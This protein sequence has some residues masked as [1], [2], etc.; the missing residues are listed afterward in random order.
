MS[1]F[2]TRASTGSLRWTSLSRAIPR[3]HC[4]FLGSFAILYS[5]STV[6]HLR[7]RLAEFG[8]PY[9]F[10]HVSPSFNYS[11]HTTRRQCTKWIIFIYWNIN[12][13]NTKRSQYIV[14]RH[15]VRLKS[16]SHVMNTL[17][18][19][20][21]KYLLSRKIIVATWCLTTICLASVAWQPYAM[22][23][24]NIINSVLGYKPIKINT[25]FRF[26]IGLIS[27]VS[28]INLS[29]S[30]LATTDTKRLLPQFIG[31]KNFMNNN[32]VQYRIHDMWFL[33]TDLLA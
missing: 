21:T 29:T 33:P 22:N 23:F 9:A 18:E 8:K 13:D 31:C 7:S 16:V 30:I 32:N 4:I 10:E 17:R 25:Y 12:H 28:Y 24:S 27:L 11:A 1:L 5:A 26:T 20:Y 14:T 3:E 19:Q 6:I 2:V 15:E